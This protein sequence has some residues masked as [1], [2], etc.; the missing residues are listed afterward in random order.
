MARPQLTDEQIEERFLKKGRKA[1]APAEQVGPDFVGA[2]PP[3][4]AAQEAGAREVLKA[5]EN[6]REERDLLNQLLGQ[7]QMANA[8]A[9]FSKTVFT[10]KLAFVKENKL[11][12]SLKGSRGENGVQFSG[13]WEEFCN[14][15]GWTP[16]HANDAIASLNAFGEEALESMSRMGIGYRDLRQ[17][18]KL[19]GD[20][21]LAL[22]EAAKAGDKGEFLDLA[23]E[24]IARHSKEK[25]ALQAESQQAKQ[26]A[27]FAGEQ[28]QKER[29][30]A[31]AAEKKLAG[32]RPV[33]VP[34]DERITP[35]Q[36]EIAERQSLIE[37]GITA[38]REATIALEKWW[39]EEVTQAE[40]YDPEAP[41]PLPRSVA[42]VALSMQ[43]SL[44]RLAEMVGAAQHVFE[45]LF[46]DDLADARQYLMQTTE[47]E[48]ANA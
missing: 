48:A 2:T 46:G 35:F 38:H 34:L 6:Y 27:D 44:N 39:T 10:S 47:A 43:D 21:Q 4:M 40:G 3:D 14:A 25:E 24:I 33:V 13:T 11:Y 18:R 42:L 37:K 36:M 41:A 30:R 17:Y 7:A 1:L 31:D 29:Q 32:K 8:F 28:L 20:A 5:A 16:Q 45:G 12:Q 19:P 23:E 15:L 22:I 9:K 26:D